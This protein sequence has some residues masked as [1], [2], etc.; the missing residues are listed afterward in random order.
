[1][2]RNS[3]NCYSSITR[4]SETEGERIENKV[5]R[6]STNKEPITDGA[7]IIHTERKNGVIPD[8]DVRTDKWDIAIE[9]TDVIAESKKLQRA[10]RQ[11]QKDATSEST[12]GTESEQNPKA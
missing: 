12:Q 8:Y 3:I 2:I 1:M 10:E 7:P 6:I 9:A 4:L 5:E 11:K